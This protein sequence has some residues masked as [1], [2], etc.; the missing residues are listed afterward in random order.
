MPDDLLTWAKA[1]AAD[2][3]AGPAKAVAEHLADLPIPLSDQIT[4]VEREIAM[5]RRVY[6]RWTAAG[7]MKPE[8]AER[9]INVMSAVLMTLKGLRE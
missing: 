1:T 4:C 9:E 3:R 6:P 7:K 2:G 5:R 8:A